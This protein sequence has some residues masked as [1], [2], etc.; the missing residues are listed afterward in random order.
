MKPLLIAALLAQTTAFIGVNVVDVAGEPQLGQTVIVTGERIVS[1]GPDVEIPEGARLVYGG[2]LSPGLMDM[3][4]HLRAEDVPRYLEN[5]ITLV[6]DMAGIDSALAVTRDVRA[7]R[8]EGPEIVI[9]TRLL[10]G[11][12]PIRPFFSTVV[13][14]A[15]AARPVVDAELARGCDFVKLYHNLQPAV[16]DAIV[17]AARARGVKVGGHVSEHVDIRHAIRSQDTI[18]HLIGY[19]GGDA[20]E[21]AR[22]SAEAGVWNVPTLKVVPQDWM[23]PMLKA[24][25]DAGARIMAGTDAGYL[26]PAGTALH[27]EFEE[28]RRAGLPRRA[29]L[30]SA[31]LAPAEYLGRSDELGRIAPG[32]LA[33]LVLVS[34]N[35]LEDLSTFRKPRAA[36]IHGRWMPL[37]TRRRAARP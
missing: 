32:Y 6:R 25:Y 24:L 17:A 26:L 21:L 2:W 36:M 34:E 7:G 15:A 31:T 4:V 19:R 22:L 29:I 8:I 11:P 18:E 3:H 10:N 5:G 35:P 23:P 12:N 27:D 30:A 20:S 33:N 13:S 14:S 9:G 16:Y 28:M 37:P 1:V